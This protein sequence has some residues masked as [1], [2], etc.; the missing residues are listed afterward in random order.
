MIELT[1]QQVQALETPEVIP[2][3]VVN[4]WTGE[5]FVVLESIR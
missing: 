5:A 1:E 3:R 4:P 2:P